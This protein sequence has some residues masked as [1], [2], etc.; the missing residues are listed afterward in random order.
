MAWLVSNLQN[1]TRCFCE[2]C[3]R[4]DLKWSS[5]A[6]YRLVSEF[7]RKIQESSY[8]DRW[9]SYG[10]QTS[11]PQNQ[12]LH[13]CTQSPPFWSQDGGR[14]A[15]KLCGLQCLLERNERQK[16]ASSLANQ[17]PHKFLP[18]FLSSYALQSLKPNH[19]VLRQHRQLAFLSSLVCVFRPFPKAWTQLVTYRLEVWP[20]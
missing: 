9:L 6:S 15:L 11:C 7:C 1:L 18:P 3:P 20:L 10:L 16:W 4:L 5:S 2:V 17:L 8:L 13:H 12:A 14:S 19:L